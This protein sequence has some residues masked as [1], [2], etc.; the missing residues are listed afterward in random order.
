MYL[1]EASLLFDF[2]FYSLSFEGEGDIKRG[3]PSWADLVE[4]VK[5]LLAL[6]SMPLV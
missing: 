4:D 6:S 5:S 2:S 1:R 3:C